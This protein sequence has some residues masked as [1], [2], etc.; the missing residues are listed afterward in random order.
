MEVPQWNGATVRDAQPSWRRARPALLRAGLTVAVLGPSAAVMA[1]AQQPLT[2]DQL[3]ALPAPPPDQRIAYGPGPLQFG[4]LRLPKGAGPHPVVVFIHGG[5][6]LSRYSISHAGPL[7]QALAD[8]G[9]A[10]WSLEYRRVGDAGGGWPGTFEDIARGADHLRAIAQR[11]PLDVSRVIAAGHSAGGMF[12]LW[13]AAR[14]RL[15]AGRPMPNDQPLAIHGVLGI[16]PAPELRSLQAARVCDDVIG[17]LMGGTPAEVPDRYALANPAQLVPLGVP[18]VLVVGE[19]DRAWG[20]V[21]RA[22]HAAAV[23]AGDTLV[24]LVEV[25]NAGHFDVI[26]PTSFAWGPVV[27]ALRELFARVAR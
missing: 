22:Y 21:G 10:V 2:Y 27:S 8:S 13:L 15:G 11:Y 4:H 1:P 19:R 17:K 3:A 26:A 25:P 6:W 16:A 18:Q 9:Y 23:A 12:A 20:P 14:A 24:R 7:E 5:C